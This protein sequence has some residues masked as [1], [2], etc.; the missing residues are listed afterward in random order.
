[1]FSITPSWKQIGSQVS[2]HMM[3]LNSYFKNSCLQSSLYYFRKINLAW[4]S[5]TNRL[6]QN[7][8][9]HPN[10][11]LN[12]RESEHQSFWFLIQLW[13]WLKLKVIQT[14]TKMQ[15][16]VTSLIHH[17]K[18]KINLSASVW[19]YAKRFFFFFFFFFNKIIWEGFS[20]LHIWMDKIEKYGVHHTNKCQ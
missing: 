16:L 10:W 13:P 6:W 15:S 20:C 17:T 18:L 7:T 5:T 11:Y 1:M 4:A 14:D 2:W 9:F 3:M 8:E 12:L 19:I